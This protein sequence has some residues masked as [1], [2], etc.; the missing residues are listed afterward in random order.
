MAE[1]NDPWWN[2]ATDRI[3][4]RISDSVTIAEAQPAQ[5]D[6]SATPVLET[7]PAQV[8]PPAIPVLSEDSLF[9]IFAEEELQIGPS[10][11]TK[12]RS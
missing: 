2:A 12:T 5:I 9:A 10:V 6:S 3:A 8:E 7:Q 1:E 11:A 4:H